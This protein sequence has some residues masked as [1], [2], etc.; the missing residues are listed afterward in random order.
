MPLGPKPYQVVY[1]TDTGL[2]YV[3]ETGSIVIAEIASAITKASHA[4][5]GIDTVGA[6]AGTG[7]VTPDASTAELFT[8]TVSGAVTLN[9]PANGTNGQKVL[10]RILNDGSHAV[11]LATGSGNFRFGTDITSYTNSV[12]LTDYIGAIWNSAASRWD[13]VSLIQGF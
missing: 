11:T 5:L 12:S 9:G 4:V 8:M 1:D 2:Q 7:T 10:F 3:F 6:V 13:V